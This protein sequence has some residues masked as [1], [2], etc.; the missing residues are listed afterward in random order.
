MIPQK[1]PKLKHLP[2]LKV[3]STS[4]KTAGGPCGVALTNLLSCWASYSQGAPACAT[5]E[6]DLKLCMDTRVS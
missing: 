2:K 6:A 1:A 4:R 3:K 5:L